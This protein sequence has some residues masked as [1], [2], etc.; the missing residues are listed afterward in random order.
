MS[1]YILTIDGGGT[2]G[3]FPAAVIELIEKRFGIKFAKKF[4][5][6]AG[7]STGAIVGAGIATGIGGK[8]IREWYET[9]EGQI[10][11]RKN[12]KVQRSRPRIASRP[13]R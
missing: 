11:G 13:A 4:D 12:T 8:E 9:K 6:V 2:R 3:A 5:L 10:F 1:K 7:T